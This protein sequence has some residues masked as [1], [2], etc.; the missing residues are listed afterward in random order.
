MKP[1]TADD[2]LVVKKSSPLDD[3]V[4]KVSRRR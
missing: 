2:D 1:E 4:V 3:L